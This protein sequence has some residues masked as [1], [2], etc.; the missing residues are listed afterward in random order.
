MVINDRGKHRPYH[1]GLFPF[2]TLPK[3]IAIESEEMDR[4]D[5]AVNRKEA[6]AAAAKLE[7][8]ESARARRAAGGVKPKHYI[9]IPPLNQ[10]NKILEN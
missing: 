2:E 9:P 6:K 3:D 4:P 5:I 8:P 1:F 7:T 10:D